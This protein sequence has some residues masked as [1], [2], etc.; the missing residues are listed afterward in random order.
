MPA[1]TGLELIHEVHN[2]RADL[3]A[4]MVTG[5]SGP[6]PVDDARRAGV[7]EILNK[8]LGYAELGQAL[9][10]ALSTK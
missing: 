1:L 7:G 10:R 3:P 6:L 5:S 9:A 8:P 4:I 2:I